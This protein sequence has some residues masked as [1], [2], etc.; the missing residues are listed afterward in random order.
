MRR[1]RPRYRVALLAALIVLLAV[2]VTRSGNGGDIPVAATGEGAFDVALDPDV[3]ASAGR[4]EASNLSSFRP[5]RE[6]FK[7][8]PDGALTNDGQVTVAERIQEASIVEPTAQGD[9]FSSDTTNELNRPASQLGL[10]PGAAAFMAGA[11]AGAPRAGALGGVAAG[12]GFSGRGFVGGSASASSTSADETLPNWFGPPPTA[13]S[14]GNHPGN[15]SAGIS[16]GH[17][18]EGG[19][20]G[21]TVANSLHTEPVETLLPGP[22]L[23]LD[24][25]VPTDVSA[26]LPDN[27]SPSQQHMSSIPLPRVVNPEPASLLLLGTGLAVVARQLR[28]R[29][30]K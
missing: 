7:V 19:S 30:R 11:Y 23:D 20:A 24:V 5:T 22:P 1:H 15:A 2:I 14:L 29:Q 9:A 3:P 28:R 17:V 18:N 16:I 21:L 8:F 25:T 13:S 26:G 4:D 27:S 10:S 6:N 12:A